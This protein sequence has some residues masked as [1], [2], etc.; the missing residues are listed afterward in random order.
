MWWGVL[1]GETVGRDVL[2]G[3]VLTGDS[4]GHQRRKFAFLAVTNAY[5]QPGWRPTARHRRRRDDPRGA[6]PDRRDGRR[7]R[8]RGEDRRGRPA[9]ALLGP[10]GRGGPRH[11]PTGAR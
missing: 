4:I 3:L 2:G 8:D 11:R 10:P 5:E 6:V 7:Q 1:L 9:R